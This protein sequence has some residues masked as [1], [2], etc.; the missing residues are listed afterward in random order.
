MLN[1]HTLQDVL[2]ASMQRKITLAEQQHQYKQDE[3]QAVITDLQQV[4]TTFFCIC[5]SVCKAMLMVLMTISV[6]QRI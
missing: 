4:P 1:T 3:L 2:E 5:C 6:N